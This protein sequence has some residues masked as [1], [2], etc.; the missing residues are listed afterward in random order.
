MA[1]KRLE[2]WALV[3]F[4]DICIQGCVYNDDRFNEGASIMTSPVEYV[5]ENDNIIT[6]TGSAYQLGEP[7]PLYE[8]LYPNA[9]RRV[10]ETLK[11]KQRVTH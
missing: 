1:I 9:K 8:Q 10:I 2:Q 7:D 6:Y 3:G 11:M 5:D 4:W